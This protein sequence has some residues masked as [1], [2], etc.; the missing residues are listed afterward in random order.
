VL[1]NDLHLIL[2]VGNDLSEFVLDV[3]GIDWLATDAT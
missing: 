1:G 2:V 3:I